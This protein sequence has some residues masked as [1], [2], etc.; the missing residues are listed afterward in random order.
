M[1]SK[2][3]TTE[4]IYATETASQTRST[5]LWLPKGE[6]GEEGHMRSLTCTRHYTQHRGK[7]P[8]IHCGDDFSDLLPK[9]E[10]SKAKINKEDYI[11]LKGF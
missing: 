11:K 4:L 1:E 10:A 8:D 6:D 7:D 2:Y 9:A 3:D 5:D